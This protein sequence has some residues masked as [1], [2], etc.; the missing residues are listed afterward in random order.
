MTEDPRTVEAAEA[1]RLA[2]I[3]SGDLSGL[4]ALLADDL[5]H[6]HATGSVDD[7]SAYLAR[8]RNQLEVRVI[9]RGPCA[10]RQYGSVAVLTGALEN[11]VRLYDG[12][13]D[14]QRT[15]SFVTQV[16]RRCTTAGWQ[17]VSYHASRL[18]GGDHG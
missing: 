2:A 6:V 12:P 18:A 9:T 11:E 3:L 15:R 8:L 1:A 4:S 5:V 7:K 13:G 16:W 10:L 17:L 14:W